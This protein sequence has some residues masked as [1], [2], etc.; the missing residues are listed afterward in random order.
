MHLCINKLTIIGSENDLWNWLATSHYLNQCWNIV[1]CTLRNKLQWNLNWNSYVFIKKMH[2]KL[3][4]EKWRPFSLSLNVLVQLF[5]TVTPIVGPAGLQPDAIPIG[6][7]INPKQSLP[8]KVMWCLK[9][10]STI[11]NK[12]SKSAKMSSLASQMPHVAV[13]QQW[14]GLSGTCWSSFMHHQGPDSI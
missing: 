6:T 13:Q 4:S 11:L 5:I 3:L 10:M 1:S 12:V 8:V 7:A 9:N 2:L 14:P